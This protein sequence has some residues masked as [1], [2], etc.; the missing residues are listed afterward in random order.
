[1]HYDYDYDNAKKQDTKL[2]PKST[3]SAKSINKAMLDIRLMYLLGK[4]K[5]TIHLPYARHNNPL[6]IRNR[7]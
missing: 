2:V 5:E 3:I 1:M 7:S 4:P 6:L